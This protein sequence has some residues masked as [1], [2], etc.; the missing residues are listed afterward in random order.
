MTRNDRYGSAP[1]LVTCPVC[2]CTNV[3]ITSYVTRFT[4]RCEKCNAWTKEVISID[5]LAGLTPDGVARIFEEGM[6][7]TASLGQCPC[8]DRPL[9]LLGWFRRGVL[10]VTGRA[11][12]RV[13]GRTAYFYT[14]NTSATVE[15]VAQNVTEE[16]RSMVEDEVEDDVR[17]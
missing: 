4:V 12:C 1:V 7:F 13:C 11:H 16:L 5:E 3:T 6:L 15:W 9:P 14:P 2:G 17:E 10:E 8:S